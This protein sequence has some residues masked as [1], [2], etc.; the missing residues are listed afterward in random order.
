MGRSKSVKR[1]LA[2]ENWKYAQAGEALAQLADI[3]AT[4]DFEGIDIYF[5]NNDE[6]VR[7]LRVSI[8]SLS[9]H[10]DNFSDR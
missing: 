2:S 9:L 7:N 6:L 3:A 10:R 4:Y 8:I 1:I 5:L